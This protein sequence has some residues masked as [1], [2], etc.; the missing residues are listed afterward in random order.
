MKRW[1]D[2]GGAE[3]DAR[4]TR[5]RQLLAELPAA[6]P[7]RPGADARMRGR[8]A[9]ATRPGRLRWW[10]LA[11]PAVLALALVAVTL[12][13]PAP[14]REVR[15]IGAGDATL[16]GERIALRAGRLSV[17]ADDKP[18]VI[19]APRARVTVTAHH[20]AVI[21]V[22]STHVV[23]ASGAEHTTI[24]WLDH[25]A[26]QPGLA[27]EARLLADA[28]RY[29]NAGDRAATLATVEAYEN[30]F[31]A[32]GLRLEAQRVKEAVRF[33]GQASQER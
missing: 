5:A 12:N 9:R 14:T 13:R 30:R 7:L 18:V 20:S 26:A 25:V 6:A 1:L 11:A 3:D 4:V 16:T 24:E 15:L 29:L 19:D 2:G 23:I 21:D 22:V 17:Q 27:E 10:A 33:R 31:P 32:G 8:L 28:L